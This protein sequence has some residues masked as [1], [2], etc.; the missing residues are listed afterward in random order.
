MTT[1]DARAT[2]GLGR[3]AG[4]SGI[5][6][7]ALL[8]VSL[9]LVRQGPGLGDP[10][11]T[12][13]AFYASGGQNLLVTVGLYLVPFARI[14]FL[15]H[16]VATRTLVQARTPAAAGSPPL[17]L[18]L[19]SGVLF[20]AMLFAG[21]A[22]VGAVALLGR[23]SDAPAPAPDVPRALAAVGYA[24]VF[25]FGVR[26]AGMYMIVTTGLL[27]RAGLI[28]R[29]LAVLG[30]LAAAFLL[31]STTFH[32]AV[33]LVFPGWVLVVSALLLVRRPHRGE[34]P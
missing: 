16:L 33:L 12:Y 15:W 2:T 13:A 19:A 5:V 28:P 10:D 11:A 26:A 32:P 14:A 17:W 1:V 8:V 31:V 6:L 7:A 34:A 27:R 23:F 29:P 22:A 24:L 9:V 20:T 25:V 4:A 30:Y 3:A 18:Q 21:T